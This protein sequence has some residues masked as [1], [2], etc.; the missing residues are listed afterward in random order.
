MPTNKIILIN[1]TIM[2]NIKILINLNKQCK[3]N[4]KCLIT[5]FNQL[6]KKSHLDLNKATTKDIKLNRWSNIEE[7]DFKLTYI[8]IYFCDY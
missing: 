4:Y 7:D 3:Y 1:K 2:A 5:S 8:F 6:L